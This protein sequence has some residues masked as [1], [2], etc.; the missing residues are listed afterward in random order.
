MLAAAYGTIGLVRQARLPLL[1]VTVAVL[2]GCGGGGGNGEAGKPP[3]Q[4]VSDAQAATKGATS[5]HVYGSGTTN[6][7]PLKL[8]LYLV[9]GKGGRGHL[10]ANGL[11]FDL[12]RIGNH[13]YFRGDAGF[14]RRFGGGAAVALL[15]GR[16]LMAPADQGDFAAFAPLTNISKLF[17][18]I[19]GGHGTLAKGKTAT[20]DGQSAIAVIDR[21]RKGG[22]LFVATKGKPYPLEVV[23]PGAKQG[24]I[25]FGSWN[26]SVPLSAPANPIDVDK[27]KALAGG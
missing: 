14:W 16:W 12:I 8:D 18:A 10:T 2:A 24:T 6:G 25:H 19:L 7:A 4:I 1:C 22:T 27:L 13:A 5:V 11:S 21:G 15:K 9:A 3:A 20:V 26:A 23:S 17:G